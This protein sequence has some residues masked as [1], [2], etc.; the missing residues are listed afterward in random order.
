MKDQLYSTKL[1]INSS[2]LEKNLNYFKSNNK[3]TKIIAMVKANAYGHGDI[4]I[5]KKLEYFGVEYFGVADFEEG[6]RLRKNQ[7]SSRIMVMNPSV[8]SLSAII[9]YNLEPVI[10]NIELFN[11]L[12]QCS[13]ALKSKNKI[14][15]HVK[16]NTGMNRWGFDIIELPTL[17][18]N[19]KNNPQLILTSLYSHLSSSETQANDS[20]TLS[21]I[22]KIINCQQIFLDYLGDLYPTHILNSSGTLRQFKSNNNFNLCRIGM[23]LYGGINHPEISPISELSSTIL[24][25]RQIQKNES[26]GYY[27]NF[28]AKKKMKIALIPFGYADGLQRSWG[29]GVLKFYYNGHFLPTVGHI[30]MDSCIV[31][32]SCI[33]NISIGDEIYFFCN[34][35]PV[36]DLA[37]ELNTISY[38]I[39]ST[40]SQRIKRIIY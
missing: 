32:V 13:K 31:D 12:I 27:R 23:L 26:V 29:N 34:K 15:F 37:R 11:S 35:R 1:S 3:G 18:K 36:W 16:I 2:S 22:K 5:T 19:I 17:I 25:I 40:L 9:R 10:Y 20:F 8:N 6:I 24:Q 33:E 21:Q 30:S 7:I 38:E 28:I 39:L 4:Q 14:Y